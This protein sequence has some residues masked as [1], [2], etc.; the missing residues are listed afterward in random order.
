MYQFLCLAGPGV[1]AWLTGSLYTGLKKE[2]EKGIL[3]AV[4]KWIAYALIDVTI[5]ACVC[6]PF[7]RMQFITLPDGTLTVHYGASALA[8]AA[9]TAVIIGLAGT[10]VEHWCSHFASVRKEKN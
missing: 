2:T 4:A 6:K 9:V 8:V 10:V 3:V 1:L 7:D 5:A